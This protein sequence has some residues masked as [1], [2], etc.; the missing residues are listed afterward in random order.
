M[1]LIK[2]LL[3][4]LFADNRRKAT[5][6]TRLRRRRFALFEAMLRELPAPAKVLDVGG[7]PNFWE[8]MGY[9][10]PDGTDIDLVLLNLKPKP[11]PKWQTLEGDARNLSRFEDDEFDLVLSNSVI[12]HV[13]DYGDQTRMAEEVRRVARGYFVQTPNRYFPIEPHFLFPLF[14]FLPRSWRIFLVR[15]FSL[16]WVP[17]LPD[18][19]RAARHVDSIRLLTT[20]EMR[21]LFPGARI[22]KERILGWTKS[23]VAVK[24]PSARP[25]SE[26]I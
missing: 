20:R 6:A 3:F 25:E 17:R 21:E 8:T 9:G 7:T 12:E 14:Q 4:R 23:L 18:R 11:H 16:G 5:L 26:A 22:Y 2:D 24:H 1:G 10:T 15:R 19:E 13:G